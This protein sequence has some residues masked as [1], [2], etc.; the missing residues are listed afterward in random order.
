M[1]VCVVILRSKN[2]SIG[3]SPLSLFFLASFF[4]SLVTLLFVCDLS[5]L[6]PCHFLDLHYFPSKLNINAWRIPTRQ[7]W[8]S[9]PCL[10][11][12]SCFLSGSFFGPFSFCLTFALLCS[13]TSLFCR[14]HCFFSSCPASLLSPLSFSLFISISFPSL[15]YSLLPLLFSSMVSN[16]PAFSFFSEFFHPFLRSFIL[17]TVSRRKTRSV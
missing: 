10:H 11:G 2:V 7:F 15:I 4:F 12:I 3:K 16:T 5:L 14:W 17:A 6:C 13:V 1:C 9:L 8:K